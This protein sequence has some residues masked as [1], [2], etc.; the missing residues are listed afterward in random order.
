MYNYVFTDELCS[1]NLHP[2]IL[3][4]SDDDTCIH[5]FLYFRLN[6]YT[7]R[8]KS[9]G[10]IGHNNTPRNVFISYEPGCNGRRF[11]TITSHMA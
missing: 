7:F 11:C 3:L 9:N 5:S 1:V 8:N 2:S 4:H 6:K 10:E